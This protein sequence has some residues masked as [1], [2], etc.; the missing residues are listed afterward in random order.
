MSGADKRYLGAELGFDLKV[1]PTLNAVGVASVGQYKFT[2]TPQV[3]TFDDLNG[4]RSYGSAN[5]KDYK[6]AGT[7]QKAFSLGLKYNSPKYWW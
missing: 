5:I 7:P 1:T 2:N 3:Y 6:V 4:F